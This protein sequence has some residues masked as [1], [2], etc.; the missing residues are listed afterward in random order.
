MS[1]G[2]ECSSVQNPF[3]RYAVEA[4]WTYLSPDE[5]LTQRG[6]EPTPIPSLKGWALKS[7]PFRGGI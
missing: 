6:G 5:A 7:L 3:I 1:L 4:G 2:A